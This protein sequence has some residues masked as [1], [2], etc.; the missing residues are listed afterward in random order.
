MIDGRSLRAGLA[1]VFAAAATV[2]IALAF[3]YPVDAVV[4]QPLGRDA[5]AGRYV[6]IVRDGGSVRVRPGEVLVP[7]GKVVTE[8]DFDALQRAGL[9][10]RADEGVRAY[11]DVA[12]FLLLVILGWL[13][14]ERHGLPYPRFSRHWPF[15]HALAT[16]LILL[17]GTLTVTGT[18]FP[19]VYRLGLPLAT[20]L[21]V[22]VVLAPFRF[23]L[24]YTV[25]LLYLLVPLLPGVTVGEVVGLVA[26]LGAVLGIRDRF[27]V[28]LFESVVHFMLFLWLLAVLSALSVDG[29]Q[30]GVLETAG[31]FGLGFFYAALSGVIVFALVT[32]LLLAARRVFSITT[33]ETLRELAAPDHPLLR[34]LAEKAPGT[35]AHVHAVHEIAGAGAAAA[36]EATEPGAEQVNPWVVRAGALFHDVGKV[37][38]PH[39]YSENQAEGENP[40]EDLSPKMSAR[41]VI[42][43]VPTGVERAESHRLPEEIVNIIRSHHGTTRAGHFF[44][45]A[46]EQADAVGAPEPADEGFRYPGPLPATAEEVIVMLADTAEATSRAL[47]DEDPEEIRRLLFEV[48]ERRA[49]E[50]QF[51]E[52]AMTLAQFAAA[53]H[54]IVDE[55]VTR[56][57]RRVSY[58]TSP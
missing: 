20:A 4:G 17:Q 30:A 49:A 34:E 8:E 14:L 26:A 24:L 56:H 11:A 10:R 27:R 28:R 3:L 23:A 7:E 44:G 48:F 19:P 55:A 12:Y 45:L 25:W 32:G 22:L 13:A 31:E 53:R 41:L 57:H 39:F 52:A 9:L 50:G 2:R 47:R 29:V 1:V 33:P 40:H 46:R 38:R 16:S 51:S 36:Q 21:L 43:H 58:R 35:M 5:V 42:S 54:A 37:D 6:S 18:L 15:L